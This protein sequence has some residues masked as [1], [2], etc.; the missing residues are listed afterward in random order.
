MMRILRLAGPTPNRKRRYKCEDRFDPAGS[1]LAGALP[2]GKRW[3][4]CQRKVWHGGSAGVRGGRPPASAI[5]KQGESI[6][7]RSART[8]GNPEA[9]LRPE[10]FPCLSTV[11]GIAA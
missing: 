8:T 1:P 4:G 10:P 6:K 5:Q 2:E 11:N 9:P 7:A 3:H